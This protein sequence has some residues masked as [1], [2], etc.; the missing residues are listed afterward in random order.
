MIRRQV[1]M[2]EINKQ[3]LYTTLYIPA[4]WTIIHSIS[5]LLRTYTEQFG[6]NLGQVLQE[7]FNRS[8]YLGIHLIGQGGMC[9]VAF[10]ACI[11]KPKVFTFYIVRGDRTGRSNANDNSSSINQSI[12]N[13]SCTEN[14]VSNISSAGIRHA[15]GIHSFKAKQT[16]YNKIVCSKHCNASR[17][18]PVCNS[19]SGK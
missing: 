17:T 13:M 19:S 6:S 11:T 4:K 3:D 12:F 14:R 15:R 1:S 2:R 9:R 7:G 18:C 16:T 10:N 5:L 8:I